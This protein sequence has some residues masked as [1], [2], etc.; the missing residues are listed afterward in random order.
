MKMV[1]SLGLSGNLKGIQSSLLYT[2]GVRVDSY[3]Y[4]MFT[5]YSPSFK[6]KL[7]KLQCSVSFDENKIC[8]L[9]EEFTDWSIQ[10]SKTIVGKTRKIPSVIGFYGQSVL[11]NRLN[12]GHIVRLGNAAPLR[13]NLK[14]PVVSDFYNKDSDYCESNA[15]LGAAY[16]QGIIQRAKTIGLLAQSSNVVVLDI[17]NKT[18]ITVID[19]EKSYP[20]ILE[21]AV[22]LGIVNEF[23]QR[24]FQTFDTNGSM[25]SRGEISN[26][27]LNKWLSEYDDITFLSNS[28]DCSTRLRKYIDTCA[29]ELY[30][31]DGI[32]TLITFIVQ[33]IEKMLQPY[34]DINIAILIG[35]GAQNYFLRNVLSRIFRVLLAS[36]IAWDDQ[37]KKSEQAAYNALRCLLSL[38]ILFPRATVIDATV[39]KG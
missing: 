4:S 38:P 31:L 22:G 5:P 23:T 20:I 39:D 7:V 2:N 11:V 37:F 28:F 24:V 1:W 10:V 21:S 32:A 16:Y 29:R 35:H 12:T 34:S 25:A 17:S 15:F 19:S 26:K 14:I 6:E 13:D 33:V 9:S 30:P 18:R 8:E 36:D 3:S 27:L